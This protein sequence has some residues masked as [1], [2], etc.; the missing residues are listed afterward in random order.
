MLL[1][2][3]LRCELVSIL[4]MR[5]HVTLVHNSGHL[6]FACG[7]FLF[8][9]RQAIHEHL[10]FFEALNFETFRRLWIQVAKHVEIL[11]FQT[12]DSELFN[13]TIDAEIFQRLRASRI[14][15]DER[16]QLHPRVKIEQELIV[17]E[18]S[19]SR[20]Q[21]G[22]LLYLVLALDFERG[23][24]QTEGAL[25]REKD[26]HHFILWTHQSHAASRGLLVAPRVQPYNGLVDEASITRIEE[27][28]EV[29]PELLKDQVDYL[30]LH[31]W[32]QLLVKVK[33]FNDQVVIV[34]EGLFDSLRNAQVEI[35]WNVKVAN[36]RVGLLHFL[37]PDVKLVR[38]YH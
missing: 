7:G 8:L 2:L 18:D 32:G 10:A 6:L 22:W 23:V 28:P 15:W 36:C 4:A 30:S 5:L 21:D 29:L 35:G 12:H 25:H 20:H 1:E 9:Q 31:L 24:V 13:V 26:F 17:A 11:S 16:T 14:A 37:D 38:L 3:Q 33:L 19:M 27:M 34:L